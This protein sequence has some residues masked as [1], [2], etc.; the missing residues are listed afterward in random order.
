MKKFVALTLGLVMIVCAFTACGAKLTSEQKAV[1][2]EAD[3]F[4]EDLTEGLN[5]EVSTDNV[6]FS[7]KTQIKDGNALYIATLDFSYEISEDLGYS[8]QSYVVPVV[9]EIL[10]EEDVYCVLYLNVDG[11]QLYRL[12]D[13]KLDPSVLD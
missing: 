3:V 1:C 2:E 5:D 10:A 4:F 7:S 11:E 8:F 12:I 6:D 13:S 9:E